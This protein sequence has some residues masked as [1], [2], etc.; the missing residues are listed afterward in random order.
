MQV[1][2]GA[3]KPLHL[4]QEISAFRAIPIDT[5]CSSYL[6]APTSH[7]LVLGNAVPCGQVQSKARWVL[8]RSDVKTS[9]CRAWLRIENASGSHHCKMP[10]QPSLISR[11]SHCN[12]YILPLPPS[13]RAKFV[14]GGSGGDPS[15]TEVPN[16]FYFKIVFCIVKNLISLP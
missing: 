4:I 10:G 5:M 6:G 8:V 1:R 16:L 2:S 3:C 14:R 9:F 7:V 13:H 15:P 11:T 12:K